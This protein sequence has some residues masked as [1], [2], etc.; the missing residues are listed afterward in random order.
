MLQFLYLFCILIIQTIFTAY[1]H[2]TS[3]IFYIYLYV[4]I[5]FPIIILSSGLLPASDSTSPQKVKDQPSLCKMEGCLHEV[6]SSTRCNQSN[7]GFLY[8]KFL[9]LSYEGFFLLPLVNVILDLIVHS[10]RGFKRYARFKPLLDLK[11]L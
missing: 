4:T 3:T 7:Y 10:I 2:E 6:H 1:F 5:A 11:R 9:H 8:I